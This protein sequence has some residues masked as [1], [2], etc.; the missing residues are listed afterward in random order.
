MYPLFQA[1]LQIA[2]NTSMAS[3]FVNVTKPGIVRCKALLWSAPPPTVSLELKDNAEL[4]LRSEP[5]TGFVSL[6]DLSPE[7]NYNV[8]CFTES[9]TGALMDIKRTLLTKTGVRTKC[10]RSIVLLKFYDQ[11]L[12][13]L[14]KTVSSLDNKLFKFSLDT[15][16]HNTVFVDV[17]LTPTACIGRSGDFSVSSAIAKPAHFEFDGD[18]RSLS[19]EF[20]VQ[21]S[22]GCYTLQIE[23]HGDSHLFK[24]ISAHVSI[25]SADEPPLVPVLTSAVFSYDG[26]KLIIYFDS[27]TNQANFR[28]V[29]P[30]ASLFLFTGASTASCLWTSTSIVTVSF[31]S[32]SASSSELNVGDFV[33]VLP[34]LLR[35]ECLPGANCASYS[36]S[37]WTTVVVEASIYS[38]S[39]LVSLISTAVVSSC[40]NILLDP[41]GSIGSAGRPWLSLVW[42]VTADSGLASIQNISS[43]EDL[44]NNRFP[45]IDDLV[46][47]PSRYLTPG[48]VYTFQLLLQNFLGSIGIK[49]V[50]VGVSD[51]AATPRA[52]INSQPVMS[53]Y[54]NQSLSILGIA[55][56]PA[57]AGNVGVGGKALSYDWRLYKEFKF[58]PQIVSM[59]L[60]KRYFAIKPYTL[61][62]GSTYILQLTVSPLSVKQS[63]T[64]SS[65][66][67][68]TLSVG[69]GGVVAAIAGGFKRSQSS[70]VTTVLDASSSKNLDMQATNVGLNYS[71][72]CVEVY[73]NYGIDVQIPQNNKERLIIPS[74]FW[75][76][77]TPMDGRKLLFTVYA[78]NS[79]VIDSASTQVTFSD[80]K[81]PELTMHSVST[82][83][84]SDSRLTINVDVKCN[85]TCFYQWS[86][87]ALDQKSLEAAVLTPVQKILTAGSFVVQLAVKANSLT[88]GLSFTFQISVNYMTLNPT[89]TSSELTVEINSP[90]YG[91]LLKVTPESGLAL[92]TSFLWRSYSWLDD[93][94]DFPLSYVMYYYTTSPLD[95]NVVKNYGSLQYTQAY[96]GQGAQSQGYA[97]TCIAIVS[98]FYDCANNAS[99]SVIVEPLT[100]PAALSLAMNSQLDSAFETGDV[101]MVSQVVSAVT[102][103]L[104][105]ANCSAAPNCTAL[106]RASCNS[107]S[108]TCGEC[109][110]GYIGISGYSNKACFEPGNRR[111]L[112]ATSACV[113][114]ICRSTEKSCPGNCS[115]NGAC[116]FYD[117]NGFTVE[118]CHISNPYCTAKCICNNGG[119]G[120]DCSLN[121]ATLQ[122]NINMRK[123]LCISTNKTVSIQDV[124]SDV[125]LSRMQSIASI[126]LD[127]D[128]VSAQ[129]LQVCADALI[130][131]V[132]GNPFMSSTDSLVSL[133]LRALS[134]VVV[135][136]S[137]SPIE[138]IDK[139]SSTITQLSL[140]RQQQTAIGE[141]TNIVTDNI[142]MMTGRVDGCDSELSAMEV[143]KSEME[144]LFDVAPSSFSLPV[145]E[146]SGGCGSMGVT[147]VQNIRNVRAD[148]T[149]SAAIKVQ[150]QAYESPLSIS[151]V[152]FV[153]QNSNPM[154]YTDMELIKRTILCKMNKLGPYNVSVLC[155]GTNAT[156]VLKCSGNSRVYL[157]YTCP[158]VYDVP[159]C[160]LWNG[161]SYYQDPSCHVV[162]FTPYNTTCFCNN[163]AVGNL[164]RRLTDA[165]SVE[166][167]FT[168]ALSTIGSDFLSKFDLVGDLTLESLTEN[169]VVLSTVSSILGSC[170]VG[171]IILVIIDLQERARHMAGKKKCKDTGIR[172]A[173]SI[174][175]FFNSL[176]PL[177]FSFKPWYRR[178]WAK[179]LV[180]HDFL[181]V[182]I[183]FTSDTDSREFRT[184]KWI[185]ACGRLLNFLFVDTILS[186]LF[187]VDTGKVRTV[188]KFSIPFVLTFARNTC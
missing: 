130:A 164:G 102:C 14:P 48:E 96:M 147:L 129:S 13:Y 49:V 76:F 166:A 37:N 143:P 120:S 81:I 125:V 118:S 6:R 70:L 173:L 18:S 78:F 21:G 187:F 35:P 145:S 47:I 159:T 29:F 157:S 45:S 160:N 3:V 38:M 57:C 24:N 84:N 178:M 161:S 153:L 51:N 5:F 106:N 68:V 65:S 50:T 138:F 179:L 126:L 107:V 80:Q 83:Y 113:G 75:G 169:A 74:T 7:E 141:S 167:E 86:S 72:T 11:L 177:E 163:S 39:P 16:P 62:A 128:Q 115:N 139:V 33:T 132:T 152:T 184:V 154:E 95:K 182:F 103:S 64:T 58:Q 105:S 175:A 181:C 112:S 34:N 180:S 87:T 77:D 71:W 117:V 9:F 31:S 32:F 108:N 61:E 56:V 8:Y 170:F 155:P 25:T 176:L 53:V 149:S 171:I 151:G 158:R 185:N 131:T 46:E 27:S 100:D 127:P 114:D 36:Y 137:D 10:C 116:V 54:R 22:P 4:I 172:D 186:G 99:S 23:A 168:T 144:K 146:D 67:S 183:P 60:D 101:S 73:P 30:C 43:I 66:A 41:T 20:M 94:S 119:F 12:E 89:K 123:K 59:S 156:F 1:P 122:A 85:D 90:P 135:R 69:V 150:L 79:D 17:S 55:S 92:N 188:D 121:N 140:G 148:M 110:T 40:D 97:V 109:F 136:G 142:R 52:L 98:D 91:G 63:A 28:S 134:A 124:T 174:R 26:I 111:K 42:S 88:P 165:G 93:I 19:E 44:L 133:V 2:T 15:R 162:S 82:K 104:N